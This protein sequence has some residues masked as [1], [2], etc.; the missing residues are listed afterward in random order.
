M[1]RREDEGD[2]IISR[3]KMEAVQSRS[4]HVTRHIHIKA[5]SK[6]Y[7]K[8]GLEQVDFTDSIYP[9]NGAGAPVG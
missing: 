9:P 3:G 1:V 6:S 8:E 4:F 7:G 2:G 5:I